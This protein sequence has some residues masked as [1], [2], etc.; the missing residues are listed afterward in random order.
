MTINTPLI[1]INTDGVK[2]PNEI[3]ILNGILQD[4][5]DSFPETLSSNISSPQGQLAT[6]EAYILSKYNG[7][8]LKLANSFD[9]RY[10]DGVYQDALCQ[11]YG[12][13]RINATPGV[14]SCTCFGV[15]G[16]IIPA[17][18]RVRDVSKNIYEAIQD[19]TISSGGEGIG[20][21]SSL[22]HGNAGIPANT[23]NQVY[24]SVIGWSGVNNLADGIPG[25]LA[26]TRDELEARRL[27]LVNKNSRGSLSAIKSGLLATT[28]VL[29]VY[30]NQ[31]RA[32]IN[33]TIPTTTIVIPPHSAYISVL[34]GADYD[35]AGEIAQNIDPG[36]GLSGATTVTW[37]DALVDVNYSI[38][39]DRP[40]PVAI[41]I[42]ASITGNLGTSSDAATIAKDAIISYFNASPKKIAASFK[43]GKYICAVNDTGENFDVDNVQFRRLPGGA[44]SNSLTLL[45]S[46]YASL[47]AT[48][49]IVN[50]A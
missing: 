36:T 28:G 9:P 1:Y 5:I 43:S 30:V 13:T 11:I 33:Y 8:I 37:N 29:D 41:G 24:T 40:T 21:F 49:V 32:G 18:S 19:I 35:I 26:E 14:V 50:I 23:V 44:L 15:D 10:A 45:P 46:E 31:N 48:D 4:I 39:F 25:R 34:G 22:I 6:A 17:G 3:D 20:F 27:A 16:T 12:I 42:V 47:T 7:E 38:T 2:A